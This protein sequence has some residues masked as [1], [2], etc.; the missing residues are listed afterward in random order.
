M[1]KKLFILIFFTTLKGFSQ[2]DSIFNYLDKKGNI[3]NKIKART[4]E[5]LTQKSDSLWFVRSYRRNGKLYNYSYYLTKK[6]KIKVGE[7]VSFNKHGKIVALSFYNDKGKKHGKSKVWFDNGNLNMEG[8]YIND[9]REGVWKV[10]H[11][12]GKLAGRGIAKN[13]SII[14][15]TYYSVK[16]EKLKDTINIIKNKKPIFKGGINKYRKKLKSL[17]NGI[18]YKVKGK[19]YVY[20]V[21]DINGNIRDV[22]IDEKL[23]KT[24]ADEII[25]F[26]N[27]LKGWE[28]AIHLNRKIPYKYSQPLNFRD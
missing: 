15:R 8:I 9:K 17:V 12:N 7:S 14:K 22:T 1:K 20:Y 4:F 13:D 10:Y 25:T 6:K 23:P 27:K 3:T 2:K 26:F 21:I 24:L 11:F 16:G 19:V 18:S 5:I 28:P